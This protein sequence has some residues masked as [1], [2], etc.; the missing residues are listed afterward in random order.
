MSRGGRGG[1]GARGGGSKSYAIHEFRRRSCWQRWWSRLIFFF[2]LEGGFG[3]G[4]RGGRGGA[5]KINSIII[6]RWCFSRGC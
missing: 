4:D 2:L 3:G 6:F 5:R 1:F